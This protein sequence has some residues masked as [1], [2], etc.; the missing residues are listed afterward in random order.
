MSKESKVIGL[1]DGS[2][3]EVAVRKRTSKEW[4]IVR[5]H[6]GT[7]EIRIPKTDMDDAQNKALNDYWS[8]IVDMR[9]SESMPDEDI[10]AVVKV[11]CKDYQRKFIFPK[12]KISGLQA[13]VAKALITNEKMR[14]AKG[15]KEIIINNGGNISSENEPKAADDNPSKKDDPTKDDDPPKKVNPPKKDDPTA[16]DDPT[17]DDNPP[18][19][20]DPTADDDP[21]K[22]DDDSADDDPPKKVRNWEKPIDRNA[23]R[24]RLK[25]AIK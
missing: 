4:I 16:D 1:V 11:I 8:K 13:E 19:K 3:D 20:D 10:S 5:D 14:Y 2:I 25:A 22:K 18:K 15:D 9:S 7:A 12:T 17:K 23:I 21:P 6:K 24:D